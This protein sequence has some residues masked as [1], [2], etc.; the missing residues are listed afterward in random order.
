MNNEETVPQEDLQPE[1][2]ARDIAEKLW[3]IMSEDE[4]KAHGSKRLAEMA[5]IPEEASRVLQVLKLLRDNGKVTF[6]NGKWFKA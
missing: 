5:G 6:K 1:L 3:N 2:T 4:E